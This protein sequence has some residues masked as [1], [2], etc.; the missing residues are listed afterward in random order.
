L[1][2]G[3]DS[4]A[5]LGGHFADQ[6][7]VA[8]RHGAGVRITNEASDYRDNLVVTRWVA[9][10]AKFY[11]AL[12]G[13]EPAGSEDFYGIP[14][15]IYNATASGANQ[16]HDYNTNVTGSEKTV[17][18]QKK[19][20]KYLFHTKPVVPVALWYPD[21]QMVMKWGDFLRKAGELRD[22]F[23]FDFVDDT[24]IL[25]GALARNKILVVTYGYV[26]ETAV[27]KK[28][29]EWAKQ[30]GRIIVV[31]VDRF[32]SVEG[33]GAP[34]DLLFPDGRPGGSFGKGY[35]YS[36]A[37]REE[38]AVKLTE[39]LWKLGYPVYEI[40]ENGLYVTQIEK[41]RLLVYSRNEEDKDLTV[42][43]KGKKTVVSCAGKSIT[44]IKL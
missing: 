36:V 44:D 20:F 14:A 25:R 32:Q 42:N 6:C 26:M 40:A 39:I 11:G 34:E 18:Q 28:L 2:T 13:F 41:D 21:A 27:A 19:H 22:Y 15:R 3:G 16:L 10:S 29:A 24:M 1:C 8:A 7:R 9:S 17:E 5:E 12:F 37:D 33:T 23:D 30:G 4:A 38:L 35:V 43:Y 31:D